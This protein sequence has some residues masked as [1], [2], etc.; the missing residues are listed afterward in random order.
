MLFISS[1]EYYLWYPY[2][3]NDVEVQ[4]DAM[5]ALSKLSDSH[6]GAKT[7]A[8]GGVLDYVPYLLSLSEAKIRKWTCEMLGNLGFYDCKLDA[9]LCGRVSVLLKC[10]S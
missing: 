7:V 5:Y 4:Q 1:K 6:N 10:V 9:K 2:S 8:Q 3:D